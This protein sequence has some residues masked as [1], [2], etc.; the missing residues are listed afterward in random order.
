MRKSYFDLNAYYVV[1]QVKDTLNV[2][3]TQHPHFREKDSRRHRLREN[4]TSGGVLQFA[5]NENLYYFSDNGCHVKLR[6]V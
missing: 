2:S 5:I 6:N 3:T 1:L 4:P